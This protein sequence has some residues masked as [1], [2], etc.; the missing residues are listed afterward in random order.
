MATQ[1]SL[2]L[3]WCLLS[4]DLTPSNQRPPHSTGRGLWLLLP[5]PPSL[6]VLLKSCESPSKLPT[7]SHHTYFKMMRSVFVSRLFP[8]PSCSLCSNQTDLLLFLKRAKPIATSGPLHLPL[9]SFS[10]V[11]PSLTPMLYAISRYLHWSMLLPV[12]FSL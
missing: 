5:V 9:L 12:L 6:Q 10:S 4:P 1:A 7:A 8:P 2:I 11:K 3:K